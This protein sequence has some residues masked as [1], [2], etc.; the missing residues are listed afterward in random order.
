LPSA[1][2]S[3]TPVTVTTCGAIQLSDVNVTLGGET[4]PSASLLLES[5]IRHVFGTAVN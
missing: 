1:R 5:T 3:S 4:V 2:V